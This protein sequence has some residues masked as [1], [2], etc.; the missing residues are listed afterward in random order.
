[1]E[2]TD[3]EVMKPPTAAVR[4]DPPI[5]VAMKELVDNYRPVRQRTVR[6]EATKDKAGALAP[7]SSVLH[8]TSSF[9]SNI[10]QRLNC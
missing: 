3:V 5:E 4:I 6:S 8:S 10:P 7:T 1:M 2:L 9:Q